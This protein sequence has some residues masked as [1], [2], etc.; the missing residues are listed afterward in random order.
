MERANCRVAELATGDV[1]QR[2]IPHSEDQ[3]TNLRVRL[4]REVAD[5]VEGMWT[6]ETASIPVATE[7]R[8]ECTLGDCEDGDYV[9]A[10]D[11]LYFM[12]YQMKED[13][14]Y[15]AGWYCDYCIKNEVGD[16][17]TDKERGQLVCLAN[18]M[19]RRAVAVA[20]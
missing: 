6:P 11:D 16:H 19:R 3:V 7:V 18:E 8:Y 13:E 20:A 12:H 5:W 15:P 14:V 4:H 2:G 10:E 9:H 1:D 17:L